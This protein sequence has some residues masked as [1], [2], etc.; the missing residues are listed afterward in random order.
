VS[1]R[2]YI[3]TGAELLVFL[4][5]NFCDLICH[6]QE[7]NVV[8]SLRKTLNDI[9]L[10]KDAAVVA[11]V[12]STFFVIASVLPC[13]LMFELCMLNSHYVFGLVS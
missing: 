9:S 3:V 4:V 7:R 13:I 10:E 12:L 11:K 8:P 2:E 1:L 5:S 6:L